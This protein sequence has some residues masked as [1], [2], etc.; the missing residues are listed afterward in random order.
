MDALC[1]ATSQK[2]LDPPVSDFDVLP[3]RRASR[4]LQVARSDS[5]T[6]CLSRRLDVGL[7]LLFRHVSRWDDRLSA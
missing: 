5:E 4:V 1:W 3:G 2:R 6:D 7:V